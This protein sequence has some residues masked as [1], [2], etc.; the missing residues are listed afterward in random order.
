MPRRLFA[1]ASSPLATPAGLR[2]RWSDAYRRG[3][4]PAHISRGVHASRQ[5]GEGERDQTAFAEPEHNLFTHI[6]GVLTTN[7]VVSVVPL[8]RTPGG[9]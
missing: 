1:V 5:H 3:S 8:E 6:Y 7:A 2:R 9:R 4:G